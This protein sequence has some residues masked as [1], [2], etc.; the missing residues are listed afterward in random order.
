MTQHYVYLNC[1]NMQL[2]SKIG[3]FINFV[4]F[5]IVLNALFIQ[6]SQQ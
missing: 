3:E 1:N 2:K 5:C 4:I 6:L